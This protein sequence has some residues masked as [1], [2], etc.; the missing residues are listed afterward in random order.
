MW[1]A[2][3]PKKGI[4]PKKWLALFPLV[5]TLI[6][7]TRFLLQRHLIFVGLFAFSDRLDPGEVRIEKVPAIRYY[8]PMENPENQLTGI[9]SN[10]PDVT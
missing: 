5:P 4:K 9:G 10:G 7:V 8:D 6:R 1:T 3:S 2:K